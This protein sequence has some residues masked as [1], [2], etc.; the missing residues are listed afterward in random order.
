MWRITAV[1]NQTADD[2]LICIRAIAQELKGKGIG[3]NEGALS[4]VDQILALTGD[5]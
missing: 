4:L 3:L 1:K 5:Q 2:R